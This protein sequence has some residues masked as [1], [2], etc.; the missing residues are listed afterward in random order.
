[1]S[2]EIMRF[3]NPQSVTISSWHGNIKVEQDLDD[4][5]YD[6]VGT[7]DDYDV[8]VI[9]TKKPSFTPGY[10]IDMSMSDEDRE[11]N[12]FHEPRSVMWLELPPFGYPRRNSGWVRV[13]VQ[14]RKSL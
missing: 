12:G 8:E 9:I 4:E 2:E 1:M 10:F 11:N 6:F 3:K 14:E 13:N 7:T 5:E